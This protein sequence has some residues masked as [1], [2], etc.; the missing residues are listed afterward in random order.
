MAAPNAPSLS[1]VKV[2]NTS[3]QGTIAGDAGVTNYLYYRDI[4]RPPATGN[5]TLGGS[6]VG[7]GT[8]VVSGCP[9]DTQIMAWALS[10]NGTSYSLPTIQFVSLLTSNTL[11]AAV[12]SKWY[13]APTLTTLCSGGL[14]T[15]EIPELV[16]I[17]FCSLEANKTHFEWTQTNLYY[18]ITYIE[19]IVYSAGAAAAEAIVAEIRNQFDW[20]DIPFTDGKSSTTYCQPSDYYISSEPLRWKDGSLIYRATMCYHVFVNRTFAFL[21]GQL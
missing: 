21:N 9:S 13:G 14:Y 18:E 12:K 15:N 8:V 7:N 10:S 17:P 6:V 2:S 4:G 19:F 20:Q 5:D 3:F 16:N 11:L 1:L